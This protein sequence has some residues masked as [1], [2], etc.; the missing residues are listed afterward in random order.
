MG[1]AETSRQILLMDSDKIE[2]AYVWP[3]KDTNNNQ[4]VLLTIFTQGLFHKG[5]DRQS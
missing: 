4:V 2:I 1:S 5:M 3:G